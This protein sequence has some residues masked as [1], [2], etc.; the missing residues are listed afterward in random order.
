MWSLVILW[1][2]IKFLVYVSAALFNSVKYLS[3][4]NLSVTPEEPAV[5]CFWPNYVLPHIPPKVFIFR[6]HF[7]LL[8]VPNMKLLFMPRFI[9][10]RTFHLAEKLGNYFYIGSFDTVINRGKNGIL[11]MRNGWK[12][13]IFSYHKV[14]RMISKGNQFSIYLWSF[15]CIFWIQYMWKVLCKAPRANTLER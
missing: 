5:V 10:R 9:Y 6:P 8:P 2:R 4:Y 14:A 1:G 13:G 15:C 12:V 7:M 11:N 3:H